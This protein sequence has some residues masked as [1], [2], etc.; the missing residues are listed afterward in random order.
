MLDK[1]ETSLARFPMSSQK[2]LDK[3]KG[4]GARKRELGCS[5]L[6]GVVEGNRYQIFSFRRKTVMKV[7]SLA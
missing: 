7:L 2:S 6:R 4:A 5:F 3:I 1:A